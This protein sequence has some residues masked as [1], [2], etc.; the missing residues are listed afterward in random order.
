[1][2]KQ[3]VKSADAI[4]TFSTAT[5][6]PLAAWRRRLAGVWSSGP[7]ARCAQGPWQGLLA[8]SEGPPDR[9][10]DSARRDRQRAAGLGARARA[11]RRWGALEL[12]MDSLPSRGLALTSV[13]P[14][15]MGSES[16]TASA[17]S[18]S[19]CPRGRSLPALVRPEL[20]L[21]SVAAVAGRG[22]GRAPGL[23]ALLLL[24]RPGARSVRG[25]S[26]PGPRR[27]ALRLRAAQ[28]E[29]AW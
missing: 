28:L 23:W 2:R 16:A 5:L 4:L 18:E 11:R 17:A 26:W 1:M 20:A 22:P 29:P 25:G 13:A 6:L 9:T 8:D 14:E 27:A 3:V 21:P 19:R 24:R 12:R 10:F 15:A 7:G